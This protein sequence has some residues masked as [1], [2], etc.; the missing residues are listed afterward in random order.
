MERLLRL[1]EQQAEKKATPKRWPLRWEPTLHA[2]SDGVTHFQLDL[3]TT[4]YYESH[5]AQA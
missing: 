4:G 5:E 1:Y 3:A 2:G